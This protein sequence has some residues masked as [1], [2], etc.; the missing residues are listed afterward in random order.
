[1]NKLA[2]FLGVLAMVAVAPFAQA[3]YEITVNGPPCIGP[4]VNLSPN[5]AVTCPS[6]TTGAG[7][8]TITDLALTGS[9]TPGVTQE[10]GTTLDIVNT[11][12]AAVAITITLAD[13]NFSSPTAPPGSIADHSGATLD[14]TT[15]TNTFQ[16]TSCVNQA[17]LLTPI[18]GT[19]APGEAGPNVP[20]MTIGANTISDESTGTIST[21]SAD[22]SLTQVLTISAGANSS[23]NVTSSQVLTPVPEPGS[24]LL[25]GSML[26]G[27]SGLLRKKVVKRS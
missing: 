5:I 24:V 18:C 21:L 3:D 6:V 26:V 22:F 11:S 10:L 19:P 23:F 27:I 13:S 14:A 16:L 1:M 15:G 9:Q 2:G 17:N 8:V 20:L 4:T 25:M 12:G 7:A